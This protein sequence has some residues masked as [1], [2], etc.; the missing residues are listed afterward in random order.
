MKKSKK[1]LMVALS[2]LIM[3]GM[4][5]GCSTQG[6]KGDKGEQGTA[7]LNGSDGKDGRDGIDGKDG[8]KI[9]TG[10]GAPSSDKGKEGDL[11]IDTE[12]GD[13]YYKGAVSWTKTGNI[14]GQNG[15]N[16]TNG[17]NGENGVSIL[18][19]SKTSSSDGADTYTITYSDGHT[20]Q[21]TVTNIRVKIIFTILDEI[22]FTNFPDLILL[23]FTVF[24][25]IYM[26]P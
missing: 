2:S 5:S 25:F 15:S 4:V 26:N 12:T 24:F 19:V 11:Y 9:Y 8:S 17:A 7:G 18:G 14:K 23:S 3:L 20:S 22:T 13:M 16:G 21:F 6:P 10:I 1:K